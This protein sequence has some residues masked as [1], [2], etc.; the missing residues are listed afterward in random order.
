MTKEVKGIIFDMDGV[1]VDTEQWYQKRRQNFVESLGYKLS[2][3]Y[4]EFIGETFASLWDKIKQDIE[5]PLEEVEEKYQ[6]YKEK[7]RINY[8]DILIPGVK[9]MIQLLKAKGYKLGLA[10]SSTLAD[11]M[12]A[13][14]THDLV[15]YFDVINSARDLG[16]P[17]PSP[18]VYQQTIKELQ[19]ASET[20]LAVEDSQA[21]IRAA[22][23]AGLKVV[24]YQNAKYNINQDQADY[25]IVQPA[26]LITV[27]EQCSTKK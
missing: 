21:G 15:S 13:L 26:Q 7:H 27:I 8:Q 5:L 11:I 4:H 24:A 9:P 17:K 10:S 6:A 23:D 18:L 25:K 1:I 19:L 16:D 2:I 22:K 14:E 3:D 20:L 12:L